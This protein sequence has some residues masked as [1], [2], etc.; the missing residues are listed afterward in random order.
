MVDWQNPAPVPESRPGPS[1][2]AAPRRGA[3]PS[4]GPG[5][6]P[7]PGPDPGTGAGFYQSTVSILDNHVLDNHVWRLCKEAAMKLPLPATFPCHISTVP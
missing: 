5:P 3:A 6:D 2:A 4:H 7:N 1:V